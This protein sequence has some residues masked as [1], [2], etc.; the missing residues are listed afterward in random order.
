MAGSSIYGREALTFVSFHLVTSDTPKNWVECAY[1]IHKASQFAP[2][3][4][5]TFTD[6]FTSPYY[7]VFA[8]VDN[9]V[10]GYAIML[11]VAGEATLMDIAVKESYR[12]R[13]I[14]ASLL[15]YVLNA[16]DRNGM[17]EVWLEVRE[18]NINAITLYQKYGFKHIETRKNYYPSETGKEHASI[19]KW[20]NA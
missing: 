13:G 3:K 9:S 7:G 20:E 8:I 2:W 14:G 12:G 6:C 4:I 1:A 18:S 15:N 19:M 16:S 5:T 11:E 17:T 10:V